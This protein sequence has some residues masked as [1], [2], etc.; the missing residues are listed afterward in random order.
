MVS[1]FPCVVA[2]QIAFPLDK[3]LQLFFPPLTSVA[4]DGLNL[5]LFLVIDKVRWGSREVFSVFFCLYVRGQKG[6]V[7][8]GMDSPLRGEAELVYY[9]RD[10][11]FN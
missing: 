9:Q 2:F 4:L 8:H 6:G 1:W 11:S 5:I 3:V 10:D 7:E